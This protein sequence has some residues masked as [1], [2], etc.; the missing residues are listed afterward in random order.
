MKSGKNLRNVFLRGLT[1]VVGSLLSWGLA[2]APT[3]S[4]QV[5][6][7]LR[8]A[9]MLPA[10]SCRTL[11]YGQRLMGIPYV[12]HTLDATDEE[13]LVIH[14]DRA[15]CT[16]LVETVLALALAEQQGEPTYAA[17][18]QALQHLR[19][20][21]GKRTD[22]L[23]RLHYFSDWIADNERK[24]I[25]TER[26]RESVFATPQRLHLNF[27]STHPDSY[28]Q[29]KNHPERVAQ[30][31]VWEQPWQDKEVFYI[32]K[33]R[34]Q[35]SPDE[36]KIAN[37]DVLAL[38]TRIEGLDVVHVGLACW[39]GAKLHLLHASSVQKKVLLDP[40]PLHDY[41]KT[42]KS[43]TGV[44]VISLRHTYGERKDYVPVL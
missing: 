17:F 31:S 14:L 13:N 44:R 26:T 8:E 12:A 5:E 11:F 10:D 36:L 24:G 6:C 32:P 25:V 3:D 38:T 18:R 42:K 21:G 4:V 9:T 41:L 23:S 30:L 43:H 37:G 34:L 28:P 16:T 40:Q 29:L 39:V 20:R 1:T 35:A 15:D 22:Y 2:A 7:L 33:E 19:Y 27:M